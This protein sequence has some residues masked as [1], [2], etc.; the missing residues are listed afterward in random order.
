MQRYDDKAVS[1]EVLEVRCRLSRRGTVDTAEAGELEQHMAL[2]TGLNRDKPFGFRD[3]FAT[4]QNKE[5]GAKNKDDIFDFKF[6]ISIFLF[7]QL[8]L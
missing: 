5:Q 2:D 7:Y 4:C 6:Q 1:I 8:K 3:Y